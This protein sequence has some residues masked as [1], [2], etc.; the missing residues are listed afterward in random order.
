LKYVLLNDK[1]NSGSLTCQQKGLKADS[2]SWCVTHLKLGDDV[3][4]RSGPVSVKKSV[5]LQE[6]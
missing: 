2:Y 4:S 5:D 3:Y 1:A 6:A